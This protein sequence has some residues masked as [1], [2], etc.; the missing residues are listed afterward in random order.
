[1]K[2]LLAVSLVTAVAAAVLAAATAAH[3]Q[4]LPA[5]VAPGDPTLFTVLVPN[6]RDHRT[7]QVSLK[8]P[9]GVIPF[10]FGETPGWRRTEKLK[11]NKSLDVV[12]W[13]GALPPGEFVEFTFLATTPDKEGTIT[14]PAVQTYH[15]GTK[16][17][18][19][20]PPDSEE[21]APVTVI[22]KSVAPQ[23]AGGE[24]GTAGGGTTVAEEAEA[25]AAP[26]AASADSGS[27]DTLAAVA[28]A[29]GGLALLTALAA[30]L[31]SR[32]RRDDPGESGD[33]DLKG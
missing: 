25:A 17:H 9:P 28:V 32:R 24:G 14:W 4:V 2:R 15:D 18:W 29:V 12:T 10:S 5:K 27:S 30:L 16:V 8:V 31:L 23:N 3:V 26:A 21:P 22:S 6:E 7:I 19:I 20:G 11:A 1:M 33:A 13:R